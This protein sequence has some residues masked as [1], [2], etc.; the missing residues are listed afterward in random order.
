MLPCYWNYDDTSDRSSCSR[1]KASAVFIALLPLHI[2]IPQI[3]KPLLFK[4][5]EC[6]AAYE[7]HGRKR[8]MEST[9]ER[10]SGIPPISHTVAGMPRYLR[11]SC[12]RPRGMQVPIDK[13]SESAWPSSGWPIHYAALLSLTQDESLRYSVIISLVLSVRLSGTVGFF[14]FCCFY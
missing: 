10:D 9:S 2:L 5:E 12:L 4:W 3:E 8:L 1:R 7:A 13:K 11:L 14:F 6:V